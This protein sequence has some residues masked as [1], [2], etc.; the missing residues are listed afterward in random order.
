MKKSVSFAMK[1]LT[2]NLNVGIQFVESVITIGKKI[3][4]LCAVNQIIPRRTKPYNTR[5]S[6]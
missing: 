3:V 6:L 4:V 1:K 5:E 2:L